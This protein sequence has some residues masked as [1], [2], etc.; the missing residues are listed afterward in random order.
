MTNFRY[1][2]DLGGETVQLSNIYGMD[3]AKFAAAFPGVT[4]RRFDS[5]AR[6]VGRSEDG[7]ILPMTRSIEFKSNPSK[8]ECD[9]RCTHATGKIMRCECPCGGKNHGK[10]G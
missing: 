8:H 9:A 10:G 4:G 7:R 3:N 5:F 1:F 2:A 6:W